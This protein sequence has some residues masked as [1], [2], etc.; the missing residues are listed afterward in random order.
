MRNANRLLLTAGLLGWFAACGSK[1]EYH[2]GA[3]VILISIDTLR[4]DRLGV[5]G[6]EVATPAIDRFAGDAIV[7]ERA[8]AHT[9]LTLPSHASAL[10]GLLPPH[11]GVRE[12]VGYRLDESETTLAEL[13]RQDGYHTGA[14]VSSMVLRQSTGIAQGF[15]AYDDRLALGPKSSV[16]TF[17]ERPGPESID[18]AKAWL[19]KREEDQPFFF[20]LH[21]FEPHTPYTPPPP[22]DSY[23][24][25]YD[26]EVAYVDHLLGQF[27]AYLKEKDLYDQSIILV[28]A[29]HGESL[30]EHGELEHGLFTYRPAIQVPF[31]LKLPENTRSGSREKHP[32]GLVDVTPT[33]LSLLE[34]DLP[35]MD[36]VP[37]LDGRTHADRD[38]YSEALSPEILYGWHACRSVING[39][40]HYVEIERPEL[41]DLLEDPREQNNLYGSRKVP[42]SAISLLEESSGGRSS[43]TAISEEDRA[44]LESLGYTGSFD[45]S[46]S[47]RSMTRQQFLEVHREI[48]LNQSLVGQGKFAEV[49]ARIS[50]LLEKYPAMLDFR[51][52]LAHALNQQD[53]HEAAE[54]LC[55]EGLATTPNHPA[56][57]LGLAVAQMGLNKRDEAVIVA[58]KCMTFAP[59]LA[60]R[61]LVYL[62]RDAGDHI[63]AS[64]YAERLLPHD[65]AFAFAHLVMAQLQ[66][67]AATLQQAVSQGIQRFSA[68]TNAAPVEEGLFFL[69]DL[70]GR[71]GRYD[72]SL[73][74]L[75]LALRA[76][77]NHAESRV[78]AT[79]ILASQNK[80]QEAITIMDNWVRDFPTR[81]NY[82]RAAETMAEIGIQKAADFYRT[83]AEKYQ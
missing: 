4:S 23:A 41:Y 40:L 56:L 54:Y 45:L 29:D 5:Y 33:I 52:M 14:V 50:P 57:L 19:D 36:G 65:P 70:L 8:Y 28:I 39:S 27:F 46:D 58:E 18:R 49:E 47:A 9:P 68:D 10:T 31:L 37:L 59:A 82:L 26:G 34:K 78:A 72:E 38:I 69:G 42:A 12:N 75:Q 13:L 53:K 62:F 1:P 64:A 73:A 71:E 6:G 24:N 32:V 43:T 7:Y 61:T 63:R 17:G 60:G 66:S 15:E 30:G 16:Q 44:L 51:V 48:T 22:F 81:A 20:W 83:E 21:L 74:V 11:H 2:P 25:P 80:G 79:K 76:N 77:P 55:M 67:G 3:P 35:A